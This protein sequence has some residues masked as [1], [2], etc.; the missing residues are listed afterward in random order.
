MKSI[1]KNPAAKATLMS[2]YDEKLASLQI[3]YENLD[4]DTSFGKTRVIKTGN[5]QG[6]PVVLF[7]GINAGAPLTIE[8][9]KELRNDYLLFAIDTIGQ[10]TKSAETVL[11]IKD[12][13]YALWANEVVEKLTISNINFIGISYGAFILQKLITHKPHIVDKCIF[14][15]PSGLANGSIWP[16]L[17]KLTFPLLR[18]MITKKDAHLKAFTK[19]FVPEND[20]FMF[21]MQKALLLGVHIDYRRPKLLT[22]N[23]VAHFNKPVFIIVASDDIFFPSQKIEKRS[24][25][26]FN[27]LKEIHYLKDTKHMPSQKTF[28]EIQQKIREWI[29]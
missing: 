23:N 26:I 8:A 10:A 17:T 29:E 2:L 12:D 11:D 22:K 3:E 15:V 18:F 27:N 19:S 21:C 9:V 5:P 14:V 24:Q 4:I 16:S 20:E 1:Y 13:S 7:H 6:K 25:E 28:S